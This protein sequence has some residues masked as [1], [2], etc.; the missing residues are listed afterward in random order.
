MLLQ[1]IV[2]PFYSTIAA[3]STLFRH[4][5]VC[6]YYLFFFSGEGEVSQQHAT[7]TANQRREDE[8]G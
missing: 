1:A 2:A 8:N 7:P 4:V 6:F 3:F 5:I